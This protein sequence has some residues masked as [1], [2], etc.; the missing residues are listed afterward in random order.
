M[1][2]I[3]RACERLGR[4]LDGLEAVVVGRSNIVGKPMA[5][6]LLARNCT[7]TIAH[8]RTRDLPG[9][10]PARRCAG[11]RRRPAGDGEG[12]LGQAGRRSSSTSASTASPRRRRARARRGSSATSLTR[13]AAASRRRDH[14]GAGRGRQDDH[15]DADGQHAGRRRARAR[16]ARAELRARPLTPGRRRRR[17][18]ANKAF[19]GFVCV[20]A[21]ACFWQEGARSNPAGAQTRRRIVQIF[22]GPNAM[23][24]GLI[25]L[26]GLLALVYGGVTINQVLAA[27]AGSARMQEISG[28]VRE[29]AQA[30]LRRQYLDHRRR[31]HRRLHRPR[32]VCCRWDVAIGFAIGA[33]LSGAAGFIGMNVSVRANVRTAQAASESLAGR[34]RHRL[35]VGRGD[36]HA[37]GGPRAARRRRLFLGADR[38]DASCA[39][40]S[41]RHRRAGGARLRRLADLDLRP[42]RRRHLHQGRRRRRRSRRQG[43]GR[44]PRGRSAQPRDHRRQCRRQCRRLRRHGGRPVRDLRRDGRR[45]D[46]ARLDLLRRHAA[47]CGRR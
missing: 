5:Q 13:E 3:D 32:P 31:R 21:R 20:A 17:L 28:A 39:R 4:K 37:G 25:I 23:A 11:R 44:H 15:R 40:R 10:R 35:Q 24:L 47:I 19:L 33:I 46:G 27:S 12:R 45:D 1:I 41:R 8:S 14:A 42:S 36:R 29:G 16:A 22:R 26:C 43:R 30:Y 38:A 7:V 2:L 34:P 18:L 9:R 6:L